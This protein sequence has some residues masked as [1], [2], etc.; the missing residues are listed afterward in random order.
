MPEGPSIVLLKQA[1]IHFSG[2]KVTAASG[3]TKKIDIQ[4][5]EGKKI[6]SFRSWGKHFLICFEEFT[7]RI[8]F[9][10]FG[11]YRIN[12]KK[13]SPPRLHLKLESGELN[14]Y[15]C[16]IEKIIKPIDEVYDWAADIMS[17]DWDEQK[18]FQ[19]LKSQPDLLACD[20]LLDQNIF[21]G[22]GNI[23]KNEV[24]YRIAVHPLNRVGN[25]PDE[26]LIAMI[27]EAVIYSFQFL[28]WKKEYTLKKHWLVH[29]KTQCPV[30][31]GLLKKEYLGK[32]KRRTFFCEQC[33]MLFT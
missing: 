8:H 29:T 4:L 7:I 12:E 23:I 5:L 3:N 21:S 30:G 1:V 32:T 9:L 26:K 11:T 31:H 16:A 25:L 15:G 6:S 10:L 2:E 19:K 20:A 27:N 14:F 17:N 22:V 33:Q 13:E 18:A 28:E 24:L